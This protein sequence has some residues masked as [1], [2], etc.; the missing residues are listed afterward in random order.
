MG[1]YKLIIV[2]A[3]LVLLLQGCSLIM[4]RN[5]ESPPSTIETNKTVKIEP[6]KEEVKESEEVINVSI[7]P[8]INQTAPPFSITL[9]TG[10]KVTN[11]PKMDEGLVLY[12]FTTYC[13]PCIKEMDEMKKIQPQYR[14]KSRMIAIDVK[15][16]EKFLY[17]QY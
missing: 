10:E 11:Q 17:F 4:L 15:D 13:V 14:S 2:I 1:E 16:A 3:F 7:G 9:T 12:F 6:A 5:Q 8:F